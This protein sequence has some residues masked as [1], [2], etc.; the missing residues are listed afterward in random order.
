MPAS[1]GLRL[2]RAGAPLQRN[3]PVHTR[4]PDPE[5]L[6]K[7]LEGAFS[8]LVRGDD[9]LSELFRVGLGHLDLRN[10]GPI[11]RFP[12]LGNPS[13]QLDQLGSGRL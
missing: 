1:S 12:L 9:P 4:L 5:A 6:G 13:P 3:P 2:H 7:D 11:T 8:V 10:G